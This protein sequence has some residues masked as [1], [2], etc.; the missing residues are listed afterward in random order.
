MVSTREP[1]DRVRSTYRRLT[2]DETSPVVVDCITN[3][4]GRSVEDSTTTKYAQ[5]PSNLTSIGM[6]FTDIL[7]Q[8]E[9]DQLSVGLTN[10][11]PLVVYTS[12]SDVFQFVH[13]LV[14]Q[15]TGSGCPVSAT[16][17]PS[18]HET[19]TVDQ[20]LPLFDRVIETRRNDNEEQELRVRKPER[21][22]W[23]AF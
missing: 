18:I 1:V 21:T 11:S 22:D 9:A 5:H 14:Q 15:S 12:P 2:D 13:V 4:L 8:H 3:A 6:K 19:R 16:I 20:F 17:D 10:L 7:E 23:E